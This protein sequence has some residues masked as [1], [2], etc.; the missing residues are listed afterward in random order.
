MFVN[1]LI[2]RHFSLSLFFFL[3]LEKENRWIIIS[4]FFRAVILTGTVTG[5]KHL[6][7]FSRNTKVCRNLQFFFWFSSDWL[8]FNQMVYMLMTIKQVTK[9]VRHV[10][11]CVFFRF[12]II[13]RLCYMS[14]SCVRFKFETNSTRRPAFE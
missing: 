14:R 13:V 1:T 12:K 7:I 6:S 8:L 9:K 2:Y 10:C 5:E 11:V 4:L 3:F